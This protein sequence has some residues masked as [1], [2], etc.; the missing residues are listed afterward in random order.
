[1]DATDEETL[2]LDF[3]NSKIRGILK[4]NQKA[5]SI[6]QSCGGTNHP[7]QCESNNIAGYDGWIPIPN[8]AD[9]CYK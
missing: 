7:D 9:K 8:N 4:A 2:G 1:M 5:P 3:M 6:C